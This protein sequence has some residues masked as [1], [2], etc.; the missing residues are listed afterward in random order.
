MNRTANPEVEVA[1]RVASLM[2]TTLTEADVHRFLLDAADILG[3]ESFAVYGPDLFFRWA[4]GDRYVEITPNPAFSDEGCSLRVISFDRERAIDIDEYLTF[5]NC[6]LNEF[7]YVWTAELGRTGFNTFGPGT[8][9][10]V[11]WEMFDE[12]IAVILHALPDNL[13]LIPPQWRRPLTLRWDMGASGLGLVS[14][15]GTVEGLTV[16]VEST[17]EQVLIPRALLGHEVKMGDVVAGLAGGRPLMDIRF[18]GSEGF[19]DAY[20]QDLYVATPNGN[21]SGWD[22]D[23]VESLI[24]EHEEGRPRAAMT[25]E[26]LRQLAATPASTPSEATVDEPEQSQTR[27]TTVPMKIGLSIPAVLHVV[28]QVLDGAAIKSVLKRLGGRPS[29]R[30]CCPILRGDGWLAERSPFTRIWSIEVVTEPKGKS[31]RF[32]DRHVA[33]YAW[34]IAQALEQRY[35]PPYGMNTTNDGYLSRLFRV[36]NHG[37]EVGTGFAAVTVETGSFDKLAEFW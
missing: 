1:D 35:G 18:A 15:T 20:Y 16:T 33:D 21:E 6:E 7:P 23:L 22:K 31:R 5:E 34:R 14:F 12:I 28:E 24:Q 8:H 36:G 27:W 25:M 32:A 29:I 37:I 13:A 9:Y 19:G 26:D 4:C 17:G 30:A 3:T 2:G 11:T 10:A